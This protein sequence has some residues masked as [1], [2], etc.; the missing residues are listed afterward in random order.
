M[1]SAGCAVRT[2]YA[3]VGQD[4][5]ELSFEPGAIIT[6]ARPSPTNEHWIVGTVD[7]KVGEVSGNFAVL[8]D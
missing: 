5:T 3:W 1:L 8:L 6:G 4:K 7:G 2:L